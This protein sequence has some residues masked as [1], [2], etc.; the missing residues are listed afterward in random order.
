MAYEGLISAPRTG[1]VRERAKARGMKMGRKPK[2][3]PHQRREAIKRRD[4]GETLADIAHSYNVSH[5]TI[6]RLTE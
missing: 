2:L 6:S 1:E 3:T 4:R 5:T